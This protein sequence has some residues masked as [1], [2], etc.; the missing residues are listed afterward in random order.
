MNHTLT[1]GFRKAYR[2]L[3]SADTKIFT[4]FGSY[5]VNHTLTLGFR[6]VTQIN[7]CNSKILFSHI[8]QRNVIMIP[9]YGVT[10]L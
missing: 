3:N 10:N 6:K 1:L 4:E 8:M 9:H 5:L 2:T 7:Y